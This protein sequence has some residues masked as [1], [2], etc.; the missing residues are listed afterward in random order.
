MLLLWLGTFALAA[1]PELHRLFHPDS[2]S[3]T[4]HCLI[5]QLQ[6]HP[7]YVGFAAPVEPVSLPPGLATASQPEF[8][9]L[10]VQDVRLALSRGPPSF[11]SSSPVA[12]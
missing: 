2:N 3:P 11:V 8:Q 6:Q 5:T 12:G 9:F 1:S 10:P 4:H 7:L